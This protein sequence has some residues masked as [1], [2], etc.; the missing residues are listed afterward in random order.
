M[1]IFH[2]VKGYM[3]KST[4]DPE[5]PLQHA[6]TLGSW[7]VNPELNQLTQ[8][9]NP[10]VQRT[11]EPRLMH[12]LCFLA[13]NPTRVLTRDQL[14]CEL[15]PRVI[16]NENSLTRAVSELRKKL[17]LPDRAGTAYLQTI[18]K[19][20]YRLTCPLHPVTESDNFQPP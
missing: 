15:W 8:I 2:K 14:S 12:L 4:L 7:R 18:P 1:V 6:F 13:A 3:S 17:A 10:C 20:G 19:R 5:K 16:V 9:N 11:M